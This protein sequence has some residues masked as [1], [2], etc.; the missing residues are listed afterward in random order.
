MA[1]GLG[2]RLR[3]L[4]H[5]LPK[6]MVPIANRPVLHH[7]L[8]LLERFLAQ[9]FLGLDIAHVVHTLLGEQCHQLVANQRFMVLD[10]G[11]RG[12]TGH[13]QGNVGLVHTQLGA[14]V[15]GI[16]ADERWT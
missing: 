13:A 2:T 3:P 15:E 1:A 4:T 11:G 5:V 7:L 14:A 9:L 16:V 8:N 6:P 10:R 12:I